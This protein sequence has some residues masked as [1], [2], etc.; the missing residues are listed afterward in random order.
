[1]ETYS[2]L[3]PWSQN[4]YSSKRNNSPQAGILIIIFEW[5]MS[6]EVIFWPVKWFFSYSILTKLLHTKKTNFIYID[7]Y[8]EKLQFITTLIGAKYQ[9]KNVIRGYIC[10]TT[11]PSWDQASNPLTWKISF[12]TYPSSPRD[13]PIVR[14]SGSR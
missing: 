11:L 7:Y 10:S 3:C 5:Q 6:R 1:M 4:C 13:A 9:Q 12:P 2:T 8:D 14:S